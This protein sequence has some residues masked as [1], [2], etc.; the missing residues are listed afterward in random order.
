MN[1]RYILIAALMMS[2]LIAAAF[3]SSYHPRE[4]RVP[5]KI[6]R[7]YTKP[8]RT[9]LIPISSG[10]GVILVPAHRP[11]RYI[12][13]TNVTELVVSKEIYERY[14]VGDIIYMNYTVWERS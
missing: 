12:L 7:K 1:K 14:E 5:H 11:E 13:V 10:K 6:K 3:F 4:I 2:I 9:I 8:V